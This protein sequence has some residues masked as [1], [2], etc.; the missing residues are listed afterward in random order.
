MGR[1]FFVSIYVHCFE[2]GGTI[3]VQN[4]WAFSGKGTIQPPGKKIQHLNF[5]SSEVPR[6]APPLPDPLVNNESV[7][8]HTQPSL[9]R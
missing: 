3:M 5:P 7:T 8:L 1:L 4:I 9:N 6:S 2:N